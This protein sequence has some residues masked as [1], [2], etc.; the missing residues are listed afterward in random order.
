MS[1]YFS[2]AKPL[3]WDEMNILMTEHPPGKDYGH[4]KIDEPPTPYE[5]EYNS[6][7]DMDEGENQDPR[8]EP[9]DNAAV[10]K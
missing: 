6:D 7:D 3:K 8:E 2:S 1:M 5:R 9:L 4:M 10:D